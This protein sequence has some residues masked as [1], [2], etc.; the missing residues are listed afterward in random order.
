[1]KK[2]SKYCLPGMLCA[3]MLFQNFATA[4]AAEEGKKP[5]VVILK[6]DDLTK[7]NTKFRRILDFLKSR[8]IKSTAGIICNSLESNNEAYYSWIKELN[9]SGMVEFWLHGF[10]HK[11]WKDAEG[12]D[13][14]EFK[15]VPYEQQKQAITRSQE[16]AKTK[17]GFPFHT[18]GAPFN[19]TD[20]TTLKVLSEDPDLKV[21]LFGNPAQ[22]ALAPGLMIQDRTAMNIENP[23]FVPNTARVEHD[24][25][26]LGPKREYF[27]IQGHPE[28]WDEARIAEFGKMI[29]Y[30]CSQGVIFTTPYEYYL[31]KQ[32]PAAHPLPA[33]AVAGPPIAA[34]SPPLSEIQA[35]APAPV[36]AGSP[37]SADK[38]AAASEPDDGNLVANGGFEEGARGWSV[39][40]PPDARGA[41]AKLDV[42]SENPHTGGQAGA[43]SCTGAVRFAIV[44]Y[45][46][47]TNFVPGDR[48]RISVWIKA[49][50]DF[51]PDPGT[52]GFLVRV[53]MFTDTAGTQGGADGLFY[54]GL[55]GAVK[56]GDTNSFKDQG[57][58]TEWTKVEGVFEV[59]P[60]TVRMNA[61]VFIW[62]GTGTLYVDDMRV[63][64]VDK[65]TPLSVGN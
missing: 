60:D 42:T 26:I 28:Q 22:A 8:N 58:P 15:G 59:A 64:A 23:L 44:N 19:A 33:P 31:Y 41:D 13:V 30:L 5:N 10:T 47:G 49:A 7:P 24:L 34:N 55:S 65:A 17:L 11:Q 50:A 16:L 53:S 1:M 46:N 6:L 14:M 21:F 32:D 62:K 36:N 45:V 12:K 38:P 57:V 3:G 35:K 37:K 9:D 18:F 25:K 43:M 61:C 4:R 48:Y 52:P 20:E 39:F 54:V 40:A 29:D 51:Q 2:Y 63:E 27:V 56:G